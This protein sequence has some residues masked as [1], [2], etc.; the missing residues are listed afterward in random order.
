MKIDNLEHYEDLKNELEN[1][2]VKTE[3]EERIKLYT[4]ELTQLQ[5]RSLMLTGAIQA[6]THVMKDDEEEASE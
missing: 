1:L 5:Q 6:L 3:V 4:Q 2:V